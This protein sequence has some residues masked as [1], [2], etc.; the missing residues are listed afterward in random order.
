MYIVVEQG[1]ALPA[2]IEIET[3]GKMAGWHVK[4]PARE[5]SMDRLHT[6]QM[7]GVVQWVGT[8]VV[9]LQEGRQVR[10]KG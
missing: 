4:V 2:G 7:S 6:L 8:K 3:L 10:D 1:E 5:D 9:D